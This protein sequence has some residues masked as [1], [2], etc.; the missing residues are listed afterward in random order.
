MHEK[1]AKN[2][3]TSGFTVGLVPRTPA[4]LELVSEAQVGTCINWNGSKRH[5]FPGNEEL[6]TNRSLALPTA[7]Q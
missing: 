2:V 4:E 5:S 3:P 6:G 7:G 1:K